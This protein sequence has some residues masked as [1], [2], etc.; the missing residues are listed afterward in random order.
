MAHLIRRQIF[1]QGWDAWCRLQAGP[2]ELVSRSDAQVLIVIPS[3][4]AACEVP[5]ACER[6]AGLL[7]IL[8]PFI[9]SSTSAATA[10]T[11]VASTFPLLVSMTRA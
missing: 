6:D 1:D 4:S 11:V 5:G 10:R 7:V 3:T 8:L 2:G 9:V